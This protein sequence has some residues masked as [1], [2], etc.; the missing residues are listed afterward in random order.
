MRLE[1]QLPMT[2]TKWTNLAVLFSYLTC[3]LMSQRAD[4]VY[5]DNS[6]REKS[7]LKQN[8]LIFELNQGVFVFYNE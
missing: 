6:V 3:S 4:W 2:S 8:S 5:A 1:T 7:S